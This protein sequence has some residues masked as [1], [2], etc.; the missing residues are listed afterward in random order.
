M[1]FELRVKNHLNKD[2]VLFEFV[3]DS[4]WPLERFA[5]AV[6]SGQVIYLG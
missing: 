3:T 6:D 4:V 5:L 2:F 1:F